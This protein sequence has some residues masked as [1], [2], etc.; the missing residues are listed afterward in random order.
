[1]QD[2]FAPP[3]TFLHR[4]DSLAASLGI[5]VQDLPD[6]I[7]I[8]RRTLFAARKSDEAATRKTWMALEAAENEAAGHGGR[9]SKAAGEVSAE[10]MDLM[11]ARLTRIEQ[12]LAS[13]METMAKTPP[14]ADAPKTLSGD[15]GKKLAS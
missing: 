6:R 1:M 10:R 9:E 7:G 12:M 2:P 4:T 3:R 13:L 5:N 14:P 8:S 11:D 15:H